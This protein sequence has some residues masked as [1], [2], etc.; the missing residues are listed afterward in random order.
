VSCFNMKNGHY[1][2]C[3]YHMGLRSSAVSPAFFLVG[4]YMVND[5]KVTIDLLINEPVVLKVAWD[6][7]VEVQSNHVYTTMLG[8]DLKRLTAGITS[9]MLNNAEIVQGTITI[10]AN[11]NTDLYDKILGNLKDM[12]S[13]N[14]VNKQ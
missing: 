11:S 5:M 3:E 7:V 12:M 4:S 13:C 8:I 2:N 6:S 14:A 9:N 10:S 1:K